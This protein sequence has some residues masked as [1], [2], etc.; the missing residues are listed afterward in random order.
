[1]S[2]NNNETFHLDI[3]FLVRLM[4]F[5]KNK[6]Q[7]FD[8]NND[9][10][11]ES[12]SKT[13]FVSSAIHLANGVDDNFPGNTLLDDAFTV[14]CILDNELPEGVSCVGESF[15][16]SISSTALHTQRLFEASSIN[17]D[18]SVYLTNIGSGHA[19]HVEAD[20]DDNGLTNVQSLG[21]F[22]TLKKATRV[23]NAHVNTWPTARDPLINRCPL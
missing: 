10:S 2:T 7:F 13:T 4:N 20:E 3:G 9:D 21:Y 8:L 14:D 18:E 15:S 22:I 1:M 6:I 5:R 19:Y 17:G 16:D 12:P 11:D 23:F